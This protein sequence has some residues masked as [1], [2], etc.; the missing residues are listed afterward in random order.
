M[1]YFLTDHAIT[2]YQQRVK[3]GLEHEVA[4]TELEALVEAAPEPSSKPSWL[5]LPEEATEAAEHY[6]MLSDGIVAPIRGRTVV[7]VITRAGSN[8]EHRRN[9]N[10]AKARR[11]RRH[12][13]QPMRPGRGRESG[14]RWQ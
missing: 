2:R 5:Y 12:K 3:P 11:R 4:R 6:L 1:K 14:V 7:A 13:K 9:K 8:T 10:A